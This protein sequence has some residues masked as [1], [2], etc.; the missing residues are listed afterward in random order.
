[1]H[2][3]ALMKCMNLTGCHWDILQE[4]DE[5]GRLTPQLIAHRTDR[6][7]GDVRNRVRDLDRL[8]LVDR[9]GP[10][11]L[12]SGLYELTERGSAALELREEYRL[13]PVSVQEDWAQYLD[14]HIN[15]G[16][17]SASWMPGE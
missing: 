2:A 9:V 13:A 17:V 4:L 3:C 10:E 14:E 6:S 12:D 5:D 1:M 8:G 7:N 11:D 15:N 16:N